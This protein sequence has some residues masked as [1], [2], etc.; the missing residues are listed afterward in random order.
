MHEVPHETGRSV[1]IRFSN[2]YFKHGH[3]EKLCPCIH[4]L[5]PTKL[6]LQTPHDL[7]NGHVPGRFATSRALRKSKFSVHSI[8]CTGV[9]ISP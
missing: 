8:D 5:I 1:S 6:Q 3:E 4:K 9:L 7:Q 2:V